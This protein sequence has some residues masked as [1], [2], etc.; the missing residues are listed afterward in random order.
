MCAQAPQQSAPSSTLA[1]WPDPPTY[2][3]LTATHDRTSCRLTVSKITETQVNGRGGRGGST[4]TGLCTAPYLH[5]FGHLCLEP[6]CLEHPGVKRSLT[7]R[8]IGT[9]Y[10]GYLSV[11]PGSL[12]ALPKGHEERVRR[13]NK[14][15]A[16]RPGPAG[17]PLGVGR[18]GLSRLHIQRRT[19]DRSSACRAINPD[20]SGLLL[21]QWSEG[22]PRTVQRLPCDIMW[23]SRPFGAPFACQRPPREPRE[24][25]EVPSAVAAGEP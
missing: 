3:T 8:A 14:D 15:P 23:L 1:T 6:A 20:E 9:D 11:S 7:S 13:Q 25:L 10:H 2:D 24:P 4:L 22:Q 17:E 12:Q 19:R 16:T 5:G 21:L 18:Q